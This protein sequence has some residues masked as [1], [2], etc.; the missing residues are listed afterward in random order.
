LEHG[1]YAEFFGRNELNNDPGNWWALNRKA[2]LDLC[3]AA[4]FKDAKIVAKNAGKPSRAPGAPN[5]VRYIAH[6]YH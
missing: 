1:A 3:K 2:L 5:Y 4:G 6:A